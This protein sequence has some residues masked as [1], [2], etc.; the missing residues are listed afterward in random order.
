[1]PKPYSPIIDHTLVMFPLSS[2]AA[3]VAEAQSSHRLPCPYMSGAVAVIFSAPR[4]YESVRDSWQDAHRYSYS[5]STKRYSHS[6]RR[7]RHSHSHCCSHD[8]HSDV[9]DF[10]L[11]FVPTVTATFRRFRFRLFRRLDYL[12][13]LFVILFDIH[14][15]LHMGS[16]SVMVVGSA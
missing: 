1:M 3:A 8:R 10:R 9:K 2:L 12:F 15:M 5:N 4:R 14:Y 13:L 16:F 11:C 7:D 6:S